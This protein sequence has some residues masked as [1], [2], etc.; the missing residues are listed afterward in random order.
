MAR[1]TFLESS[2]CQTAT[3]ATRKKKGFPNEN[4]GC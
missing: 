3:I 4:V 2:V 1:A